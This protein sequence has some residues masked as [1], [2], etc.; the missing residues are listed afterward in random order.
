MAEQPRRR[1]RQEGGRV[2]AL[3]AAALGAV[4]GVTLSFGD[5]LLG[6]V[7]PSMAQALRER[8][9]QAQAD[10]GL[11]YGAAAFGA[12]ALAPL[13]VL[14]QAARVGRLARQ[15]GVRHGP[16]EF[17][18]N[19]AELP[20]TRFGRRVGAVR[21]HV[22]RDGPNTYIQHT[23]GAT[24]GAQGLGGG[25]A[26]YSALADDAASRGG[27]LFS[28]S[29]V[30]PEA[31]RVYRSLARRGGYRVERA[32]TARPTG[33]QAFDPRAYGSGM[34]ERWREARTMVTPRRVVDGFEEFAPV[35][36][37]TSTPRPAVGAVLRQALRNPRRGLAAAAEPA[38]PFSNDEITQLA[39]GMGAI[40]GLT[41]AAIPVAA[42]GMHYANEYSRLT[43]R[44]RHWL[45][46]AQARHD[47]LAAEIDALGRQ[48]RNRVR[49]ERR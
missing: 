23:I 5:E 11:A 42:G 40:G 4:D 6:L 27:A 34:A 43:A 10:Q 20:V 22:M 16:V 12:G 36:R 25:R 14:G 31:Q 3:E 30:S 35:F 15:V 47:D 2:G 13:G 1:R 33:L 26:L 17:R 38:R 7:A 8:Q 41:A 32:D 46:D 48:R 44:Y 21:S 18:G 9:A 24:P 37:V 45:D 29:V 19:M 49:D 39:Y 28:D